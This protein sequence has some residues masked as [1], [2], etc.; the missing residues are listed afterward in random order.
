MAFKIHGEVSLDG[1]MFKR[2]LREIGG[3][4]TAFFKN[5]ALGVV[6]IASIEQAFSK[7]IEMAGSLVDESAKLS[8][9]IE[10]LQVMKQAAKD[11]G[12]EWGALT[13]AIQRYNAV[14][15]NILQG[16]K[17]SAAQLAALR[18]LG[19]DENALKNQTAAQSITGQISQ[20]AQKSNLADIA[21]DLRQIFGK[22]GTELFGA[23]Q[24]DFGELET[25]MRAYGG[26]LDSTTAVQLDQFQDEMG[27]ISQVL[28]AEFAPAIILLGKVI[29][30]VVTVLGTI[31]TYLGSFAIWF[32][33]LFAGNTKDAWKGPAPLD[34]A[35][36]YWKNH[37]EM[38]DKFDERAKEIGHKLDNP[39]PPAVTDI[40]PP[41]EKTAHEKK[42]E[43]D[44]LIS[45]GN[46]LGAGRGAISDI[47]EQQLQ[48]DKM[49]LTTLEDILD[50]LLDADGG[51][52]SHIDWSE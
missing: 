48:I 52:E 5:F 18:R 17:S 10:K 22:G 21:N 39:K 51:D 33:E 28:M 36:E 4:T 47:A 30:E 1:A 37:Q 13:S 44:S 14:R 15:E 45:T 25:K 23:L 40:P 31:G 27:L 50:A 9:G 49:Q 41:K 43:S 16:G 7:T 26:I 24:T 11:A 38:M 29:F 2:G 19:I 3:E 8:V 20:T 35:S 46:F 6:G 32:N 42:I 12:T 34:D